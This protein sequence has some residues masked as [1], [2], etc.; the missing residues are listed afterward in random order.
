MGK[1]ICEMPCFHNGHKF[2]RSELFVGSVDDLPKDK[3]GKLRH[4]AE[5]DGEISKPTIIDPVVIVN[6]K[7][8]SETEDVKKKLEFPQD[9]HEKSG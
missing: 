3:G 9:E 5:I 6:K 8:H 7:E 4:F 1:F 2:K